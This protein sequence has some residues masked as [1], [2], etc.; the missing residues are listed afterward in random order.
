MTPTALDLR[1][2]RL[3]AQATGILLVVISACAF[4]SVALFVKPL[5]AAGLTAIVLL[6]WRFITAAL[7]S[8]GYLLAGR[9]TRASLRFLTR[10]RVIVLLLLGTLYVGN[11]FTYIG[12]LEVVPISLN[13]IIAYL[14]PAIVAVMALRLVR[15]LEGRRAYL[16][17]ALSLLGVALALGGVPAGQMPPLWGLL[18]SFANPVIYATWI[19]FQSRVAGDRPVARP[20]EPAVIVARDGQVGA[21]PAAPLAPAG[22]EPEAAASGHL[23]LPPADAE[24][25]SDI[26]DPAAAA[27]L[28]TSATAVVFSVLALASGASLS[29]ADVPA[30]AWLPLLGLGVIATALAIQTFYAGVKR[31]GAARASLISTIEPVYTIALAM[32]LFGEHLE[33]VQVLGG[34]IVLAAVILAETGRPGRLA[35]PADDGPDTVATSSMRQGH[36]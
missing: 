16:A 30:E 20:A 7:V 27:A 5:Y 9:R 26:P 8:W 14:Y 24:T 12:A 29:P 17:L 28:M 21:A 31:V 19:V 34:G 25:L 32:L 2:A 23:E 35:E 13:S 3:S 18:L 36:A 15:R 6:A 33:P 10:R 4:G 11:S 1:P 22:G